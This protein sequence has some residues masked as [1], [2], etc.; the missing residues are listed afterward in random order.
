VPRVP[1][2]LPVSS[3]SSTAEKLILWIMLPILLGFL[4]LGII[5]FLISRPVEHTTR[6]KVSYHR[7]HLM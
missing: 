4:I 3:D 1:C 6:V 7:Q 2:E 5:I